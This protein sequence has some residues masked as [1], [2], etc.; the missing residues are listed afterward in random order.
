MVYGRLEE[1]NK[2]PTFLPRP[3]DGCPL[4]HLQM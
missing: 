4:A 3:A 2:P 1:I